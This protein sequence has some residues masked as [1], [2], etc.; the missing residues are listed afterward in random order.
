MSQVIL[1][2]INVTSVNN[3]AST[4]SIPFIE[5]K[6]INKMVLSQFN[7]TALMN[8]YFLETSGVTVI[9][10]S[11]SL[12]FNDLFPIGP[13][14]YNNIN[15]DHSK[16]LGVLVL[17]A[18]FIILERISIQ[19]IFSST[20]LI[21]I[22]SLDTQNCKMKISK[23]SFLYNHIHVDSQTRKNTAILTVQGNLEG[24]ISMEELTF[25]KNI[26]HVDSI[27]TGIGG[28][29]LAPNIVVRSQDLDVILKDSIF[30]SSGI[31]TS[32]QDFNPLDSLFSGFSN[33]FAKNIWFYTKS[34]TVSNCSFVKPIGVWWLLIGVW[35][36]DQ[37]WEYDVR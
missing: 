30:K 27:P 11:D 32:F 4:L 1:K 19:G 3:T 33:L 12:I 8:V 29:F 2:K 5:A 13:G 9:R 26:L 37:K 23:S 7:V 31:K 14:F 18:Y 35:E 15:E 21:T 25:E 28:N 34:A 24:S 36:T 10:V 6:F 17:N 22:D 16:N 20:S